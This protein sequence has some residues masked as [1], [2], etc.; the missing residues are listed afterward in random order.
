[1][2]IPAAGAPYLTAPLVVDRT[3]LHMDPDDQNAGE[4]EQPARPPLHD[5]V[6]QALFIGNFDQ[7]VGELQQKAAVYINTD[8]NG[9]GFLGISGS[10]SLERFIN[11]VAKD[12]VDPETNLSAWKRMYCVSGKRSSR[13]F[14]LPR[15]N[16]ASGFTGR[17]ISSCF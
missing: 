12:V 8:S 16:P 4:D 7:A 10:H 9:R 1:M 11:D 2:P 3:G 6:G 13:L 5:D 14:R 15:A 17:K